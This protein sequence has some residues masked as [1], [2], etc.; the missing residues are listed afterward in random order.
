M[1]LVFFLLFLARLDKTTMPG[2]RGMFI[3]FDPAYK[4]YIGMLRL[5]HRYNVS[6]G[7]GSGLGL[8]GRAVEGSATRTDPRLDSTRL[9]R[10]AWARLDCRSLGLDSTGFDSTGLDCT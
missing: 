7:L 4:A 3:K 1:L 9:T 6:S 2:P 8:L 5:D 10:E